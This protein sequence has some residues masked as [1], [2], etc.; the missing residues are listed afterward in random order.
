MNPAD[1]DSS[2]PLASASEPHSAPRPAA[3]ASRWLVAAI[4]VV[5]AAAGL[6]GWLDARRDANALRT[7]LAQRL[8]STDAALAL[9]KSREADLSNDLRDAQAKLTLL[10]TRVGESQSQQ[11]ALETLYRDLAPSRDEL[12][13]TEI[14]QVPEPG[15]MSLLLVGFAGMLGLRRKRRAA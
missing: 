3:A 15:T 10:E 14:E 6:L 8:A 12:A 7:D 2:I 5:L 4:A 13:F 11:A 9:A 1:P